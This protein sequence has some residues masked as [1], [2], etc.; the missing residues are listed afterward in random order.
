[1]ATTLWSGPITLPDGLPQA[2]LESVELLSSAPNSTKT[3]T[4][5]PD[6]ANRLFAG[7]Q[8]RVQA[9]VDITKVP[10]WLACGSRFDVQTESQATANFFANVFVQ[11]SSRPRSVELDG[12]EASDD[13]LLA[14]IEYALTQK[15]LVIRVIYENPPAE[16]EKPT[17]TELVLYSTLTSSTPPLP[18]GTTATNDDSQYDSLASLS[19]LSVYALP[20]SSRLAKETKLHAGVKMEPLEPGTAKFLPPLIGRKRKV[21]AIFDEYD[22]KQAYYATLPPGLRRSWH[23]QRSNSFG[24]LKDENDGSNGDPQK[25]L[26]SRSLG[27]GALDFK[28]TINEDLRLKKERSQ[29]VFQARLREVA[30]RPSTSSD[31]P[32]SGKPL[33]RTASEFGTLRRSD[34]FAPSHSLRNSISE[35]KSEFATSMIN[36]TT[37]A[38]NKFSERN[39]A[40]AQKLILSSM[41]LY[42]FQRAR[43]GEVK[44]ESEEEEYKTVF[45]TTLRS[46]ICSLRKSWNTEVIGVTKLK[47]TTEYL[48]KAF[49]GG[50]GLLQGSSDREEGAED[51]NP[52]RKT[53]IGRSRSMIGIMAGIS[54]RDDTLIGEDSMLGESQMDMD[55]SQVFTIDD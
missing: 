46:V 2:T 44:I 48:M 16:T 9:V 13:D 22:K 53:T 49:I 32:R 51:D 40:A 14:T 5:K 20:L 35:V 7:A 39:R 43:P 4:S 15:V 54:S 25:G 24:N 10:L 33:Q 30:D 18:E 41:R 27:P 19:S 6:T 50:M 12:D 29:S 11:Q 45:N 52:F 28:K 36:T 8:L 47:E 26:F 55:V 17:I 34:S 37:A 3:S 42:G 21:D 38:A 31:L 1:M 23:H